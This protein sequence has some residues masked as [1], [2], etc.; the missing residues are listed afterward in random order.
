[1]ALA[2]VR[3]ILRVSRVNKKFVLSHHRHHHMQCHA[4]PHPS[5]YQSSEAPTHTLSRTAAEE[6]YIIVCG[7]L[8]QRRATFVTSICIAVAVYTHTFTHTH[9]PSDVRVEMKESESLNGSLIR[10]LLLF[11]WVSHQRTADIGKMVGRMSNAWHQYR[12]RD[13]N[14]WAN[15]RRTCK[16]ADYDAVV[17][18]PC[19]VLCNA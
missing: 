13:S 3:D 5:P 2:F 18:H 19:S 11:C 17:C 16:L 10:L 14:T 15:T 7:E 9:T 8:Y 1:M 6:Y 4:Q 12:C